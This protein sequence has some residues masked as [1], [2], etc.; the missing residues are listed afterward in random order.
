MNKY[1][2][3]MILGGCIIIL[4][5]VFKILTGQSASVLNAIKSA[6]SVTSSNASSLNGQIVKLKGLP[7]TFR[8][9]RSP[10]SG[11]EVIYYSDK[12]MK[13]NVVFIRGRRQTIW[14]KLSEDERIVDGITIS[15]I[16]IRLADLKLNKNAKIYAD[17][18]NSSVTQGNIGLQRRIVKILPVNRMVFVVGYMSQENISTAGKVFI[19]SAFTEPVLL[20]KIKKFGIFTNV[21]FYFFLILGALLLVLPLVNKNKKYSSSV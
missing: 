12:I 4:A 3:I 7:E 15:G 2:R 19:I 14:Q 5:V 20:K 17:I 21:G 8:P 9:L 13:Q 1:A 11:K 18:E 16:N 10:Y 6:K